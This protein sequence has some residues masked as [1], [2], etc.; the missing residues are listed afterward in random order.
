MSRRLSLKLFNLFGGPNGARTRVF[1]VRGRCPRPLDD[2]TLLEK[3]L[4]VEVRSQ[5]LESIQK[6]NVPFR[7]E[8]IVFKKWLGDRDSNPDR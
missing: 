6:L 5:E 7:L 2:G 3:K 8:Y 4:G 1:G